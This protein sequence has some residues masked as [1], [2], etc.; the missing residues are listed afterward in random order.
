MIY[1]IEKKKNS[2]EKSHVAAPSY[3]VRCKGV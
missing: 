3:E 1:L 2:V